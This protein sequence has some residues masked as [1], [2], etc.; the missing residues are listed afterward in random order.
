[1]PAELLVVGGNSDIADP[2]LTPEIGRLRAIATEEGV[3]DRVTFTGR[4]PRELLKLYYSAA[5]AFVTTPWYEAF[6]MTT[7]EAMACGTPVV[8]A[9]VGGIQYTVLDQR[10]GFLVP[11]NDPI[12]LAERLR[13]VCCSPRLAERFASSSVRRAYA[14]FRLGASRALARSCICRAAPLGTRARSCAAPCRSRYAAWRRHERLSRS[15]TSLSRAR[16]GRET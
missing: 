4:R 2:A 8:G 11:P 6:G 1:M 7:I 9:R 13:D 14:L 15:R 16:D 5:D 3:A 12:V 10:T